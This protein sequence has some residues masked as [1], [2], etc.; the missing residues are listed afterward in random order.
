MDQAGRQN[1][2][3]I[4]RG[5]DWYFADKRLSNL[6]TDDFKGAEYSNITVHYEEATIKKIEDCIALIKHSISIHDRVSKIILSS[7][8]A[9]RS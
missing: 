7:V 3:A 1:A 4:G 6:F 5:V 2:A 9:E 8:S